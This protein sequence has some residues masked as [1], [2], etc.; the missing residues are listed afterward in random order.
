MES[1]QCGIR[2]ALEEKRIKKFQ[3]WEEIEGGSRQ[4]SAFRRRTTARGDAS[5]E[6]RRARRDEWTCKSEERQRYRK[7]RPIGR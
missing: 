1:I 5:A 4:E 6:Y 3:E 7:S 2:R